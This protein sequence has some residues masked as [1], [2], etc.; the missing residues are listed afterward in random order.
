[1]RP[2]SID[3]LWIR[4][5]L[6]ASATPG[7]CEIVYWIHTGE[8]LLLTC[9]FCTD[10]IRIGVRNSRLEY[11]PKHALDGPRSPGTHPRAAQLGWIG[12]FLQ[13]YLLRTLNLNPYTLKP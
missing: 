2:F 1:M 7:I 9:P 11:R 3:T 4:P 12:F 13:P 6:G 10:L 5:L 8:G